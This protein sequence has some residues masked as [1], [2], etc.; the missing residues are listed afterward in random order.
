MTLRR[1]IG[2]CNGPYTLEAANYAKTVG[3]LLLVRPRV[4]GIKT[5]GFLE[6]KE[7]RRYPV[8]FDGPM[9][10]TDMFEI[11][12]PAGY[13]VDELPRPVDV[14]DG[15]ASYRSKT[16][17]AGG[18]LR[19]T[20]TLEIKDLSVPANQTDKLK[21]FYRIIADDERNSAVLKRTVQ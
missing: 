5:H 14:D 20:R 21:A 4:L 11:E 6:T 1:R 9:R 3:D 12:L 13:Q 7:P 15:F 8:E 16:E 17:M 2:P 18:R 19:Y 10:D